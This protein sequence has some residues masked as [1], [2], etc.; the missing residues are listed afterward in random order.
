MTSFT[1]WATD[2][3]IKDAKR[4]GHT[5]QLSKILREENED[6]WVERVMPA[7]DRLAMAYINENG[8]GLCIPNMRSEA[9]LIFNKLR[10]Q[11]APEVLQ[12]SNPTVKS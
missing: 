10:E 9:V 2:R 8:T 5:Q 12:S 7:M 1:D 6:M 11:L 3:F 4:D